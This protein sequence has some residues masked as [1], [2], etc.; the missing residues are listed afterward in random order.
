[1]A[2]KHSDQVVSWDSLN[3]PFR[4]SLN[5]ISLYAL[6]IITTFWMTKVFDD[7]WDDL[8]FPAACVASTLI[9]N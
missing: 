8:K 2:Q 6:D 7:M 5:D 1:M 4:F 3:I 9:Q